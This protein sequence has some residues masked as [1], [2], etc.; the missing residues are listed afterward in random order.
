VLDRLTFEFIGSYGDVYEIVVSG[1][2]A[3]LSI[4]CSCHAGRQGRYC[5]HR[6]ALL[7]GDHARLRAGH[8]NLRKL[9]ALIA[10]SPLA[11]ALQDYQAANAAYE[12][13]RT[14]RRAA[15]RALGH[16]MKG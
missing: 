7:G 14:R 15:A 13:A 4:T 9:R 12:A 11:I 6:L 3:G 16:L 5:R 10:E 8:D 1:A 2:G